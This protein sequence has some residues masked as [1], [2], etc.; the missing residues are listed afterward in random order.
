MKNKFLGLVLC[1]MLLTGILLGTVCA[2]TTATSNLT[3]GLFEY[4]MRPEGQGE[5]YNFIHFY[6]NGVYY[7]SA[8]NAAQYSAGFY[9]LL[10]EPTE[11]PV[12]KNNPDGEK[13][14]A[15]QTIVFFDLAGNELV[16]CGYDNDSIY[17]FTLLFNN[18]LVHDPEADNS[19]GNEVGIA[20]EEFMVS[21]DEYSMLLLK[22]NGTFE[23]SIGII[24]EGTWTKEGNVYTLIDADSGGSYT[25]TVN[26]NGA[27]YV[28]LDGEMIEL[29]GQGGDDAT[30]VFS[31]AADGTY[32]E[33]T[34][35]VYCYE[36]GTAKQVI[37]YAGQLIETSGI[38]ELMDNYNIAF[39][40]DDVNYEAILNMTDYSYS[41]DIVTSDGV[42]EIS[43]TLS[44]IDGN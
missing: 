27:E 25:L 37:S 24:M 18:T 20:I 5:F 12:D 17:F 9:K 23:D 36:E 43:I 44:T 39:T 34:I 38:W 16:R 40:F 31:G 26:D 41:M 8:Y 28:G 35:T 30:A 42:G 11:Y 4:T 1:A 14:T 22:H 15:A 2:E 7:F 29:V 21:G 13:A 19:P 33:L 32:G 3:A 6:E 10:D